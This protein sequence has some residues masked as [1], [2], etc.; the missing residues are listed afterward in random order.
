MIDQKKL[1][2]WSEE[3]Y[4]IACQYGWHDEYKPDGQWMGLIM[5]EIGEAIEADRS[6]PRAMTEEQ[7]KMQD[8]TDAQIADDQGFISFYDECIKGSVEEEFADIVIRLLDYARMKWRSGIDFSYEKMYRRNDWGFPEHAWYLCKYVLNTGYMNIADS[9]GYVMDWADD[10]G[11]NL[12]RHIEWKIRY[13]SLRPYRHGG[14]R[15]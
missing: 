4:D 2:K 14:K 6:R 1:R 10:L 15:Y 5:S 11:I 9:I 13:N 12:E 7:W 8:F 3:I